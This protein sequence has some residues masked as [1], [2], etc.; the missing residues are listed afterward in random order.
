MK[1][2]L[3]LV[4]FLSAVSIS[5]GEWLGYAQDMKIAI[6][7]RGNDTYHVT[8]SRT[9]GKW[10]KENDK[11][12]EM[13]DPSLQLYPGKTSTMFICGRLMSTLGFE[14]NIEI[15]SVGQKTLLYNFQMYWDYRSEQWLRVTSFKPEFSSFRHDGWEKHDLVIQLYNEKV[16]MT[17]YHP[18]YV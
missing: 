14:A 6:I 12:I 18:Y 13:E 8:G 15:F 9:S 11:S 4:L 10:Y 3:I 16:E 7:N 17:K 2:A 5:V 1:C